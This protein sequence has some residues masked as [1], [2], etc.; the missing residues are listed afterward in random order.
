MKN[1]GTVKRSNFS[2]FLFAMGLRLATILISGC[3]T[4]NVDHVDKASVLFERMP[5]EDVLVS[6]VRAVEDEEG[7]AIHGRVKRT[8]R[9]CCDSARGHVDIAVVGPDG[10]IV[11]MVSAPYSPRNIPKGRNRSSRFTARLPYKVPE[12]VPLRITYHNDR[13]H[14]ASAAHLT[15]DLICKH[16]LTTP[17]NES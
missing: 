1:D 6:E 5:S 9:N 4:T 14:A 12:D 16:N 7:L 2:K 15:D 13:K 3:A 10:A 8:A 11:D 17:D